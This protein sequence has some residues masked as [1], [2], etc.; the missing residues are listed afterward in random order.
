MTIKDAFYA[1]IDVC[2]KKGLHY[3]WGHYETHIDFNGEKVFVN[4]D[5]SDVIRYKFEIT[6]CMKERWVK[7]K[8]D[9]KRVKIQFHKD[10]LPV[11]GTITKRTSFRKFLYKYLLFLRCDGID[12]R[13]LML[14]YVLHCLYKK[15]EFWRKGKI[16]LPGTAGQDVVQY[17]DWEQYTPEY[18]DVQKMISG[19]IDSALKK[20]INDQIR[21]QFIDSRRCVVNTTGD[22]RTERGGWRKLYRFEKCRAAKTGQRMAT[23]N[24]IKTLYDSSLTD[25]ENAKNIGIG[26]RRLQEWKS[27]NRDMFETLEERIRRMYDPNLSLR[28]N[29]EII[30]CSIN[31]LKKYAVMDK[32]ELV[33][34]E[35]N[36]SVAEETEEEWIMRMLSEDD[37]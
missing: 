22:I 31:S 33:N 9:G 27:D 2:Q 20:D 30:D 6:G 12:D 15:F 36:C 21:E 32:E 5:G 11:F 23:D 25:E 10:R 24:R 8:K 3:E 13:D 16:V 7:R 18:E 37:L 28:K 19:L 35:E 17:L 34:D 29:A 4:P 26:V 1:Q 14:L